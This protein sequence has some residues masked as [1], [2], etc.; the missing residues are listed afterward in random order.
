MR[1]Q[2]GSKLTESQ[3]PVRLKRNGNGYKFS[4]WYYAAGKDEDGNTILEKFDINSAINKNIELVARWGMTEEDRVLDVK[5]ALYVTSGA[6]VTVDLSRSHVTMAIFDEDAAKAEFVRINDTAITEQTGQAE[7]TA[8]DGK[9][10][11]VLMVADQRRFAAEIPLPAG[12][13]DGMEINLA[14]GAWDYYA[15]NQVTVASQEELMEALA[16]KSS[17]SITVQT[18]GALK[19][20]INDSINRPDT[21]IYLDVPNAEIE[22][23]AVLGE[24][25]LRRPDITWT[26]YARAN[27]IWVIQHTANIT[28]TEN[29]EVGLVVYNWGGDGSV[30][31]NGSLKEIRVAI[32][33]KADDTKKPNI[34]VSGTRKDNIYFSIYRSD[35]TVTTSVPLWVTVFDTAPRGVINFEEGSANSKIANKVEVEVNNHSGGEIIFLNGSK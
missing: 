30:V 3:I 33:K 10:K 13:E 24:V 2:A 28:I 32:D 12:A 23:H 26:E 31:V 21:K 6:A 16:D 29:A 18:T 25:Y 7:V 27:S 35:T 11:I 20:N 15:G 34:F 22:N 5:G 8:A 14:D 1:V 19:I 17:N 9:L 4:G